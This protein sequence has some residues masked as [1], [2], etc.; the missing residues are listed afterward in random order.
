MGGNGIGIAL[1]EIGVQ[2]LGWVQRYWSSRPLM[3]KPPQIQ[4]MA[5]LSTKFFSSQSMV[6]NW[7]R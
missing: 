2:Q 3:E 7:A 6:T 5:P 4:S 1:A